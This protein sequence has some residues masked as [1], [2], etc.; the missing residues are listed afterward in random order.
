MVSAYVS[1]GSNED[2]NKV[3]FLDRNE[4]S[5]KIKEDSSGFKE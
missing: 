4:I 1:S 5:T 3:E 2:F